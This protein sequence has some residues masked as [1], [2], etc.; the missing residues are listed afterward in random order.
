MQG[1]LCLVAH[2]SPESL[3][4]PSLLHTHLQ[5][6]HPARI[7]VGQAASRVAHAEEERGTGGD[8]G[9]LCLK[10]RHQG[11][12][13]REA[14]AHGNPGEAV[15][16][17]DRGPE[18]GINRKTGSQSDVG[19]AS[20]PT[21]T[22]SITA[23]CSRLHPPPPRSA[24]VEAHPPTHPPVPVASPM[25]F[26][27]CCTRVTRPTGDRSTLADTWLTMKRCRRGWVGGKCLDR[28]ANAHEWWV[29][30]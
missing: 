2:P 11:A 24:H 13:G 30:Q 16:G 18:R 15:C 26:C 17:R 28:V 23:L 9:A 5:H 8:V 7:V 19:C 1:H 12:G 14:A 6:D 25:L 29:G 20:H 10:R 22:A 21:G 3:P 4:P 27:S